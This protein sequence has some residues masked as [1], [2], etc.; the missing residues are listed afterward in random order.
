M[1]SMRG[2][3]IT[4]EGTEGCG[5][6]LQTRMLAQELKRRGIDH[7][8][9][10]QPGGTAFGQQVREILLHREGPPREPMAE[11]LLYLADR[12]QNLK[13]VIEP[14]L[15]RGAHVVC[16][17]YQDATMAYQAYARGIGFQRVQRLADVLELRNPDLTLV[18]EIDIEEGLRR[19]QERQQGTQ[20]EDFS[21]F[22]EE[23]LAFHRRV[24]EGYRKLRQQEPERVRFLDASGTP[25]EVFQ[26][27][28]QS[29]EDL[30]SRAGME[31]A[32]EEK[33]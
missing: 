17:R 29:I 27:V 11:L 21:R 8:M 15:A 14:A 23:D 1:T 18:L 7:V 13:Q 24:L 16:D 33:A 10:H 6:S 22:E 12:Y 19:A 4:L 30:L 5:K 2:R 20:E 9:T 25:E 31:P 3:F 28:W 32:A 26:R